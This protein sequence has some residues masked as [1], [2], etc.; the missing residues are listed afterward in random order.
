[1]KSYTL[2]ASSTSRGEV[3]AS[4]ESQLAEGKSG[5]VLVRNGFSQTNFTIFLARLAIRAI[6][7]GYDEAKLAQVFKQVAAG[8]AS[9]ARHACADIAIEFEGEKP[10]SLGKLWGTGGAKSVPDLSILAGL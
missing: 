7:A 3:T 4:F 10:Q 2:K 9:Q 8:N 5:E 6:E 1:M